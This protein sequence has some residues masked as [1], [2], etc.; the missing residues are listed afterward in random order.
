MRN[1][2]NTTA[3]P[4]LDEIAQAKL[5]NYL[6]A[7][8][9]VL[10]F[11]AYRFDP[12]ISLGS[13][14]YVS[15]ASFASAFALHRWAIFLQENEV[16][17]KGRL[18][19][20]CA[21]IISDNV[22]ISLVL[23]VGG[24]SLAFVW[25]FYI[26]ISVGYG[27]RYGVPYL[28]ST[29]LV[30]LIA[31]ICVAWKTPFWNTHAFFT[32]GLALAMTAVPL[33]VSWLITRLHT[34]VEQR[35][36]AYRAKSEF[37]ARMS[38]ELRTPLHA[39]VSTTDLLRTT[40]SQQG[41]EELLN[42]ISVSSST[43]LNL[44]NRVLDLSKFESGS[45]SLT[46]V[47]MN[48]H[49]VASEVA[50]VIWPEAQKKGLTLRVFSD[51]AICSALL[52]PADQ[53][54]EIL[55]NLL[56][57]AA[58]FTE[59]GAISLAINLTSESSSSV[60]LR[61][62]VSDTGPGIAASA[63]PTIF[64]AFVQA[65]PSI[66]RRHGGSGLGTSFARELTRLMGGTISV[67]SEPGLGTT[68]ELEFSFQKLPESENITYAYPMTLI[69]L[70]QNHP[71]ANLSELLTSLRVRLIHVDRIDALSRP[72]K[73]NSQDGR[74]HGVLVNAD[75]FGDQL[76]L[77]VSV[78]G[79]SNSG[80]AIP[81]VAHGDAAYRTS[82]ISAGYCS[83]FSD[84]NHATISAV[85][86]TISALI[87][88]TSGELQTNRTQLRASHQLRILAADDDATNRMLIERILQE[89]GHKCTVVTN[90]E[91]A[92]FE[93][94]DHH[95]DLAILDM[96][97]PKRDGVEVAKIYRFSRFDSKS[98]IPIILL[99]ADSTLNARAEAESAG[100]NKFLTKP[101]RPSD[102]LDSVM[103]TYLE[104]TNGTSS[105]QPSDQKR[106]PVASNVASMDEYRAAPAPDR[107]SEFL[108]E[109]IVADL[110]SFMTRDE[111]VEFFSDFCAD[112][113]KY[114]STLESAK[115]VEDIG[116]AQHD[117]HA[118]VGAAVTVGAESLAQIA[119]RIEHLK[120]DE[121]L[122]DRFRIA[123]ELRQHCDATV[124]QIKERYISR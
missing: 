21:S 68:F 56:G 1:T 115:S 40:S 78:I 15:I 82:A 47:P 100:I 88:A 104:S 63:L 66:K 74:V 96:H 6:H 99:T 35:E 85:L 73:Q 116:K 23:Y 86:S 52:G 57:N 19:Q 101:I 80:R 28:R 4:D 98:P 124:R 118:L 117:M 64:D 75:D 3:A 37:V 14:I 12:S 32:V 65:D 112:A 55:L 110:L 61:I 62:L 43:L 102:L 91:D 105:A 16:D 111:Q 89:A 13:V 108:N 103:A 44:I 109:N 71:S 121:I 69:A 48:V 41:R 97:M 60:S 27:V 107:S 26:W 8:F 106:T 11:L 30:S 7:I 81:A 50:T 53:L 34:A 122:L 45:I 77:V 94:H 93:L 70:S 46:T 114:V 123:R 2:D 36:I 9:V 20:R 119:K 58:K 33:Y 51:P 42:V 72:V 29:V 22:F 83:F 59:K 120:R 38:H 76:A 95:Y 5:R 18:S 67:T 24:Q 10:T 25:A 39:I 79:R 113:D 49:S 31:F 87:T 84:A 92:L 54:K 90:G 17:T